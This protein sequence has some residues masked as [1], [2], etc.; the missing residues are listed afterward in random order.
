M[1]KSKNAARLS[2]S[3]QK[4]NLSN[5]SD[6]PA[7]AG[8]PKLRTNAEGNLMDGDVALEAWRAAARKATGTTEQDLANKFVEEVARTLDSQPNSRYENP[9]EC[10]NMGLAML[11]G[12]G[13]RDEL[14]AML[15]AQMVSVHNMAMSYA[16]R[17]MHK[18]QTVIGV[19]YNVERVTKLMRTFTAQME[20]L[21][22]YRG[23]G[24]QK[25][26]VEH[27]HIHQGGRA[28]V[29]VVNPRGGGGEQGK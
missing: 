19:N 7:E 26:I 21:A 28:I 1:A 11:H 10:L 16:A 20:A 12:I 18:D 5:S 25:V 4:P 9:A 23:K 22:R 15:A 2:L 27:V 24:Q 6:P 13:P 8:L 29:G 14:E 17:A 3:K